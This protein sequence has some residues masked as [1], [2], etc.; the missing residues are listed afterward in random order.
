MARSR[1]EAALIAI[2]AGAGVV[3]PTSEYVFARPRLWR[4]DLAWPELRLAVEVE[5][6]IWMR[7]G[8]HS[9]GKGFESDCEKYNTAAIAGW[10][11]LRVTPGMIDDGRAL[12]VIQRALATIPRSES[13]GRPERLGL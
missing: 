10:K 12:E 6:G 7:R 13:V 11:V 8:H 4:F 9:S 5:G 2:L 1:P 3:E